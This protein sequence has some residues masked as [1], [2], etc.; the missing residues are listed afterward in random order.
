MPVSAALFVYTKR[1][2]NNVAPEAQLLSK[3]RINA[4]GPQK[5]R[6]IMFYVYKSMY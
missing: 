3:E 5:V 4:D 1:E 6:F 2:A